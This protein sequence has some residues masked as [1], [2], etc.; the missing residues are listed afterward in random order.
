MLGID[1]GLRFTGWGL[2]ESDGNRLRHLADGVIA[3]DSEAGVPE[4]LRVLYDA[5]AALLA[6]TGADALLMD[7]RTPNDTAET[8]AIRAAGCRFAVLDDGGDRRLAAD[9]CFY[10]PVGRELD[11]RGARGQYF[12]GWEWLALRPQ[13]SPSPPWRPTTPPTALILAGGSDA[14]GLRARLLRAAAA[15]LPADWRITLVLGRAVAADPGFDALTA[16]LG[17]RLTLLRDVA[18]MAVLMAGSTLAVSLFGGTAYELAAVGVPALLIGLDVDHARSAADL[19]KAGAAIFLGVAGD[20]N[21]GALTRAI[22]DLAADSNR[23]TKM[24]KTA[25]ALIDGRGALRIAECLIA[26][27]R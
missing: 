13:F 18:E 1:P 25:Q 7:L 26:A 4:R 15:A 19:D 21:D 14:L 11:W 23:R 6:R 5:L 12:A 20:L 2:V 8:A 24:S 9:L 16:A 17:E 10:P 22:G 3:T 27:G